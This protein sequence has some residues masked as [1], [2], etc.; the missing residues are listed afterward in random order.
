[1]SPTHIS[2]ADLYQWAKLLALT[3]ATWLL[4]MERLLPMARDLHRWHTA[5][6][7]SAAVAIARVLASRAPPEQASAIFRAWQDRALEVQLQILAMHR[8]GRRWRPTVS[9][10]GLDHLAAALER[11]KGAILWVSDFVY[12][13][14]VTKMAFCRAGFAV[15]HL[16]RPSHGFS[17]SPFGIRHLNPWWTKVEDRFIAERVV[18][19]GGDA[20]EALD[21]LRARLS[22]NGVVSI[23]VAES[24]RRTCDAKFFSGTV[25]V[26]TGPAHLSRKSRAPLLPVFTLRHDDGV[27]GVSVGP[28]LDLNDV[29]GPDYANA[30][31][32]YVAKLEPHVLQYP[33]QWNGWMA[34]GR[35]FEEEP[36]N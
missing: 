13:S 18:I 25:R 3:P 35:L 7:G 4:P 9:W 21:I 16:S 31:Q 15:S 11:R 29:R 20:K 8:P 19:T 36:A 33:D 27:Y 1:M 5:I 26:A 10:D 6:P 2:I 17:I 14:L 32:A 22:E 28:P 12:S 23:T 24:A 34:L 30:V